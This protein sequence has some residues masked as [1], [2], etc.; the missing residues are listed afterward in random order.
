MQP[1][2]SK[3]AKWGPYLVFLAAMLWASDAPFRFHLAQTLDSSFIVLIEHLINSLIILPFLFINWKEIKSLSW[4]QWLTLL[5][6]AIGASAIA[7]I[8][9]TE[10]F[11]YSNP[12]VSIL[13]QKLQPLI[14]IGLAVLFLGERTGRQFW[15]WTVV[16]LF[17]AYVISFP[18][19]KP[20]LYAGEVWNPNTLGVLFALGA[21]ILWGAGTVL[22]RGILATVSF[23]TV[24]SLRLFLAFIFLAIWNT[25]SGIT[26]AVASLTSK[27]VLF[28]IIISLTSGFISLFVYYKGLTHTK[29]SV[30]TVAELG[31]PFLAV[32]V[33]AAA[34][35]FFLSGMQLLG[36]ALLLFAIVKLAKG[37]AKE[38]ASAPEGLGT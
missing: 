31:F 10:S 26:S 6:I 34:L 33:N 17:G 14:A 23:K 32:I 18:G 11:S 8:L 20:E 28:L 30:A 2:V 4:K 9:F 21:A 19:L 22:G 5:G 7:T 29:A 37:N 36:M 35:G 3:M 12:S 38:L 16:A 15:V 13:L 27:D 1:T 25:P 24:A